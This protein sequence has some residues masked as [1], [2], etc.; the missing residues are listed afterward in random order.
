MRWKEVFDEL[1]IGNARDVGPDLPLEKNDPRKLGIF[2]ACT[3]FGR[4][5][6]M[7]GD[8]DDALRYVK[9]AKEGYDEQ[10]GRD[11]GKALEVTAGFIT[12]TCSNQSE[13]IEKLRDLFKRMERALGEE[14]VV[15]LDTL[16]EFGR[17]LDDN[18]EYEEAKEVHER[19]LTGQMKVLGEDHT[20]TLNNLGNVYGAL[21]NNEKALEYY[22]RALKGRE[23]TLGTT[24]PDMIS[25]TMNIAIVYKVQKDYE[26]AEELYERA[27][28]GYEAQ[29][30]KY[31]KRTMNCA[32]N[33]ATC[34]ATAEE[35]QKIR[36]VLDEYAVILKQWPSF[37]DCL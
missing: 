31:H 8:F 26:K 22:E 27:L 5:C 36:E 9:R 18:G 32:Q 25:T 15:T 4:A 19:C 23:K 30:G 1:E 6:K 2:D 17:V 11:S 14:N 3:A 35:T 28:E 12:M 24:H 29:L 20:K 13:L 21:K 7:V 16:N 33:F 34:L 37:N 10:L